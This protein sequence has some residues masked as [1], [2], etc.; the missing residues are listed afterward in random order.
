MGKYNFDNYKDEEYEIEKPIVSE[1]DQHNS[2]KD[3]HKSNREM[4]AKHKKYHK[5]EE[6]YIMEEKVETIV[7]KVIK[8]PEAI[9]I[10]G[11]VPV[12]EVVAVSK[13][14]RVTKPKEV[15]PFEGITKE[16]FNEFK[17]ELFKW[18]KDELSFNEFRLFKGIRTR[19]ADKEGKTLM[20]LD[21]I[22]NKVNLLIR[23]IE[24]MEAK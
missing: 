21:K 9:K 12:V 7:E 6:G 10:D 1:L 11:V 19:Q 24:L 23:K 3:L 16:E 17:V 8:E 2:V 15:L 14:K 18:L 5:K 22:E 4:K 13:K 20:Q